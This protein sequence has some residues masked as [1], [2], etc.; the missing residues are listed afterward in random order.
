MWPFANDAR[1]NLSSPDHKLFENFP[2]AIKAV[3]TYQIKK[4]WTSLYRAA[5][6]AEISEEIINI[7]IGIPTMKTTEDI[8]YVICYFKPNITL[9]QKM[10]ILCWA[11]TKNMF[12]YETVLMTSFLSWLIK[13]SRWLARFAIEKCNIA[14][15][16]FDQKLNSI[17]SEVDGPNNR[18][19]VKCEVLYDPGIESTFMD[20]VFIHGLKGDKLKTWNQGVWKQVDQKPEPVVVRNTGLSTINQ[21][22]R[23]AIDE[24]IKEFTN[25]WPRDWL[26]LDCPYVRV[27]AISYSTDPYLWR[28]IWLSKPD[29]TTMNDRGLEMISLLKNVHVGQHPIT[30]VGHSK[31]GLFIKQILVHANENQHTHKIITNTRGILFYSVPHNGSPLANIKLPLFKRSIELQELVNDSQDIQKLQKTFHE[32]M[33]INSQ[34]QVKSFIETKLTLMK[35]IYLRIVSVQSADPG[36]GDLYGVPLDHRNICKPKNRNCFLYQELVNMIQ[37]LKQSTVE[38]TVERLF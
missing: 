22:E 26:P 18:C 10:L 1:S 3:L 14:L 29:R 6:L 5:G 30:W 38:E 20:V 37:S 23:L 4:K 16:T 24:E 7:S 19:E 27:I 25:C 2:N 28:P 11:K 13:Y 9:Y 34:I 32:I 21:F 33:N 35:L 31:G 12:F 17:D 36:F 15:N 8:A